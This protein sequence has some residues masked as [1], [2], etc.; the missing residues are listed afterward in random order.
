MR[1]GFG[2]KEFED[3]IAD[4]PSADTSPLEEGAGIESQEENKELFYAKEGVLS[5][6]AYRKAG[7]TASDEEL[8]KWKEDNRSDYEVAFKQAL[9]DEPDLVARFSVNPGDAVDSVD[10]VFHNLFGY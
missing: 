5:L 3:S 8:E 1:Q 4:I 6:L 7:F 10:T 2:N 9:H